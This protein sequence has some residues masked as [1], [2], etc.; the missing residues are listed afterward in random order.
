MHK[1]NV[2]IAIINVNK[3]SPLIGESPVHIFFQPSDMS[4]QNLLMIKIAIH[5]SFRTTLM[6]QIISDKHHTHLLFHKKCK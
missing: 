6:Y 2:L 3:Y 4:G 1:N 5:F